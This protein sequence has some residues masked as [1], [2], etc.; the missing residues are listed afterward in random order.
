MV[1]VFLMYNFTVSLRFK[2]AKLSSFCQIESNI[3]HE[4]NLPNIFISSLKENGRFHFISKVILGFSG[5]TEKWDGEDELEVIHYHQST[6]QRGNWEEKL[7]V[8][9]YS[10]VA[11]SLDLLHS[12]PLPWKEVKEGRWGEREV[13]IV[14]W[15]QLCW[16]ESASFVHL[17]PNLH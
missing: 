17:F 7:Y 5:C 10:I 1:S 2:E 6:I 16:L 12:I 3:Y 9:F 4:S 13:A 11:L 14:W 15:N 8:K